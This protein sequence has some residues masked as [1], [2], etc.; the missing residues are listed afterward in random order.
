[1]LT[2]MFVFVSWIFYA[3]IAVGLFI[4]RKKLKDVPR[5]YKVWGYPIVPGVFILFT[6]FYLCLTVYNDVKNYV[7]GKSPIIN[8]LLGLGLT[9]AGVPL[10]FYF[11]KKRKSQAVTHS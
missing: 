11:K 10:Y 9:L 8:S 6:L 5:L 3:I 1:M 4:L 2:D 7:D